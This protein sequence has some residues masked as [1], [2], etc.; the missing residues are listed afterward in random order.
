[1]VGIV[2]I[3]SDLVW[4]VRRDINYLAKRLSVK[5]TEETEVMEVV[6]DEY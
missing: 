1:M 4:N 2:D 3:M 6:T 5:I